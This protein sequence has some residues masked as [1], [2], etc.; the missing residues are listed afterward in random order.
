M[1]DFNLMQKTCKLAIQD[2]GGA[3]VLLN[4]LDT[5][6][7]RCKVSSFTKDGPCGCGLKWPC[8]PACVVAA[9]RECWTGS[10]PFKEQGGD[11][12]LAWHVRVPFNLALLQFFIYFWWKRSWTFGFQ[13]IAW[14]FSAQMAASCWHRN[15]GFFIIKQTSSFWLILPIV[16][17][18]FDM[19]VFASTLTLPFT[20]H[21]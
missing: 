19:H 1:L 7:I 20:F 3:E 10:V 15:I 5:D 12:S 16:V 9:E 17:Q 21:M 13:I 18:Y 4:L 14:C 11:Y 2:T 6:D 8:V